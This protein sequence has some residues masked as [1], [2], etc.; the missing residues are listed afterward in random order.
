MVSPRSFITFLFLEG[1]LIPY[2]IS[3]INFV[4]LLMST[5]IRLTCCS[6]GLGQSPGY[7]LPDI[8]WRRFFFRS[9]R[10]APHTIYPQLGS[11][12]LPALGLLSD[13]VIMG[14]GRD[15]FSPHTPDT[16]ITRPG[17]PSP[18]VLLNYLESVWGWSRAGQNQNVRQ[19]GYPGVIKILC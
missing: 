12:P 8:R 15:L 5:A 17:P 4:L 13:W 19:R 18:R 2:F 11:L 9:S 10:S 7:S 6:L 3:G 16:Y 14:L 1:N